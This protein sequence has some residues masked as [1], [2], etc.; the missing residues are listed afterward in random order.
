MDLGK[1]H[2][3][4]LQREKVM[5]NLNVNHKEVFES[6]IKIGTERGNYKSLQERR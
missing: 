2:T 4:N 6:A 3:F 1:K 5:I